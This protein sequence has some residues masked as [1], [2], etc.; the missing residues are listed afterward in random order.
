MITASR[1]WLRRH[2]YSLGI[3]A[4]LLGGAYLAGTYV[5]GKLTDARQRMSDDRIAK[6][7]YAKCS[8]MIDVVLM[9]SPVYAAASRKIKRTAPT[10]C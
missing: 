2:R 8:F 1:D 6:E 10:P 7:K 9:L 4:G 5:I 3:S